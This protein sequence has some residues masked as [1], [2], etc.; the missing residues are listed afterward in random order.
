MKP[1]D[2]EYLRPATVDEAVAALAASGGEG[3]LLAGGQSLV[4]LMNFRLASPALLVDLNGV[5]EL[6][7]VEQEDGVLRVGSMTRMR[8]LE[9]DPQVRRAVPLLAAASAWVGHVQIRN[10]G[11]VGGSI[12]HA[13]PAAEVPAVCLLA[14]AELVVVGP[15]GTRTISCADF[16]LGFLTTALGENDVLTEIRVPVAP[17][18]ERWGFREFAHRRGDFA[19]AGAAVTL[20]LDGGDGVETAR[21]V[22]FGTSDRPVRSADAEASLV[23]GP[24]TPERLAD[25]ARIAADEAAQ[26]DPRPDAAYRRTVTET[27]VRR[28]LDDAAAREVH[29]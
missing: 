12:A 20:G 7:H 19:L 1:A 22:V 28:A 10:R 4:P 9:T 17:A 6:A 25:T 8:V 11:T 24:A 13:D 26:D 18:G 29:A 5:A 15:S 21:I 14:D 3:K 27:M 16:F 23:G 2:F